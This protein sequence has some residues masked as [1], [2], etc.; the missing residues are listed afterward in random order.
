MAACGQQ[1]IIARYFEFET[2]LKFYNL[3]ISSLFSMKMIARI[4][5]HKVLYSKTWNKHK[6]QKITKL[7]TN[8][9]NKITISEQTAALAKSGLKC[10]FG[11]KSLPSNIPFRASNL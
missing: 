10:M 3:E 1:P 6:P 2:V 5:S 8:P 7:I 4:D 11:T 9:Q